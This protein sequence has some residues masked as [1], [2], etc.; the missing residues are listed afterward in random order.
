M[1]AAESATIPAQTRFAKDLVGTVSAEAVAQSALRGVARG[2]HL[3][4]HGVRGN[5]FDQMKRLFPGTFAW[6]ARVLLG[7]FAK[8]K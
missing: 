7:R 5:I 4:I 2:K 6:C 8:G 3:I 1:I